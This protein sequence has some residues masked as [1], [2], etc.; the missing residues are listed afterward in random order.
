MGAPEGEVVVRLLL[1]FGLSYVLGFERELRGSLA[2]DRT[3]SLIGVGGA[4]IGILASH[5]A[6]NALTGVV[7]GIGFIG[8]GL[9]FRQATRQGEALRG[10]TTAAAIFAAAAIGAAAGEGFL[11][12][13]ILG[14]ALVL[15][16]LE[17][18][19]IPVLRVFDARRWSSRFADDDPAQ[20]TETDPGSRSA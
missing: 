6:P 3:F 10:I 14:T 19:H 4:V 12:T 2:G 13:A 18:R 9:V 17:I 1:A 8:G 7:T 16:I 15:F 20:P 5:G 11:L